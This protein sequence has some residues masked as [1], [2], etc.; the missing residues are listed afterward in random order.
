MANDELTSDEAI[1]LI[2]SE[3]RA[4]SPVES[5]NFRRIAL[6]N[7]AAYRE[8]MASP[9]RRGERGGNFAIP[10]QYSRKGEEFLVFDAFVAVFIEPFRATSEAFARLR[11]VTR[12]EVQS[13]GFALFGEAAPMRY[14]VNS[15][16]VSSIRENTEELW[17]LADDVGR[18][19]LGDAFERGDFW[20][21]NEPAIEV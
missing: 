5:D 13:F 9:D 12:G 14:V 20:N 15:D 11:A 2:A 8:Q 6:E 4:L 19:L 1:E 3:A 18:E 21:I 17:R 10:E 7:L 16:R